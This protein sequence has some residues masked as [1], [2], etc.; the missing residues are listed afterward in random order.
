M[1]LAPPLKFGE[2]AANDINRKSCPHWRKAV[3]PLLISK[4]CHRK[5]YDKKLHKVVISKPQQT[6]VLSI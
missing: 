2:H 5:L 4:L 6:N 1:L 3:A